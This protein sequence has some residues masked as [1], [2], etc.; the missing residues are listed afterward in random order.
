MTPVRFL[1]ALIPAVLLASAPAMEKESVNREKF[2]I[3][4][5]YPK[6]VTPEEKYRAIILSKKIFSFSNLLDKIL[7]RGG[8]ERISVLISPEHKNTFDRQRKTAFLE[9]GDRFDIKRS[10]NAIVS[11]M[12][13][14]V[15]YSGVRDY[16]GRPVP[17]KGA[18]LALFQ[19]NGKFYLAEEKNGK[20]SI[21]LEESQYFNQVQSAGGDLAA[22]MLRNSLWFVD[23]KR[24]K[25]FLYYSCDSPISQGAVGKLFLKAFDSDGISCAVVVISGGKSHIL[26]GGISEKP[27]I[28]FADLPYII[29]EIY[30]SGDRIIFSAADDT[31]RAIVGVAS[32]RQRKIFNLYSM[33]EDFIVLSKDSNGMLL[34]YPRSRRIAFLDEEHHTVLMSGLKVRK[35]RDDDGV[36]YLIAPSP[37]TPD[38]AAHG[39]LLKSHSPSAVYLRDENHLNFLRKQ[40][41]SAEYQAFYPLSS[42]EYVLLE[43]DAHTRKFK[44]YAVRGLLSAERLLFEKNNRRRKY[45]LAL[46]A[47]LATL[48]LIAQGVINGKKKQ[49]SE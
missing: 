15:D 21:L 8:S 49:K 25:N 17:H 10:I 27:E 38:E 11:G 13:I 12:G 30:I 43:K 31:D 5:Q 23:I 40:L 37:G 9:G 26:H 39:V 47:F 48:I 29:D 14:A 42:D 4:W 36:K 44:K 7:S 1:F 19:M 34:F 18:F 2:R 45:A 20:S 22:Y 28:L 24:K 35:I 41:S 32:A 3:T 33:A 46:S 16:F 6:P